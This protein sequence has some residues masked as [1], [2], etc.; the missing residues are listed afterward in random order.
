[1]ITVEEAENMIRDHKLPVADESLP[2]DRC[3]GK[4]LREDLFADRDFPPYNRVTMD[5]IAIDYKSFSEGKST[6]EIQGVAAA[7]SPQ[8]ALA[9]RDACLEVMTG[10][11]LPTGTDTVIRYE[12]L[13]IRD[14]KA[15]IREENIVQGQ[16]IHYQGEDRVKGD[17]IV[18]KGT[19]LSAAEIGI[20]ATIGKSWLKVSQLPKVMVISTGDELVDIDEVPRPHE[21]RR[22]NIYRLKST[23][24]NLGIQADTAHLQDDKEEIQKK[25]SQFV[26]SYDVIMLSGGVSKGKFDFLPAALESV[27]VQ[28]LF[29]K[30]KQRPGK[31]FWFGVHVDGCVVFALPG[32]PVSSFMCMQRY[33]IPWLNHSLGKKT[34]QTPHAVLARPV[35]FKPDLVY[36]VQVKINFS[37]EGKLLAFPVEGHGS[38]DLANLVEADGFLELP[39]G[40]N[41]F[42]SGEAY[43][44]IIFR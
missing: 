35:E 38:G 42:K 33:F 5:G 18:K 39:R 32:N 14:N 20:C 37:H 9:N 40:K 34:G 13:E 17:L 1:M 12:D 21:I 19:T 8:L 27:G 2:L 6:M 16:N 24:G 44:L 3:Y 15:T 4:V 22:S 43:P 36:F 25:L 41:D 31:P 30:I 26:K 29:H 10:S 23:L 11:I 28:K 7:G